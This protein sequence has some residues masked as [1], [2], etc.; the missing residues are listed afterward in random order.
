MD[1]DL[2]DKIKTLIDTYQLPYYCIE[3][4]LTESA[5]FDDKEVILSTVSKLRA[6]GFKVSMDDFGTGYSSL[7][8]LKNLSLDVIKLDRDFFL[9][10]E[11]AERGQIVIK[12]T[13]ALA[14][15]LNME[16]VAEGIETEDQV[17][18]LR[19]LGCDM[20]Q[21]FYFAKPMP[22]IEF[23]KLMGYKNL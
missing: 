16:I 6:L 3:L 9:Y 21:G 23:E 17:N 11:N 10:N 1:R 7:N 19:N 2:T 22:I 8:S 13:I 12:D 15:D 4:E 14:K 5:F 20:I 18:F